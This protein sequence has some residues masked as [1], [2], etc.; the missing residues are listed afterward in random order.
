MGESQGGNKRGI[1]IIVPSGGKKKKKE[2]KVCLCGSPHVTEKEIS[3]ITA[4]TNGGKS[5]WSKRIH[6]YYKDWYFY[7]FN[8]GLA[9]NRCEFQDYLIPPNLIQSLMLQTVAERNACPFLSSGAI[10]GYRSNTAKAASTELSTTY[11]IHL[12]IK[13]KDGVTREFLQFDGQR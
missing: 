12:Q 5:Y 2:K 11:H 7:L 3:R 6:F 8:K 10:S 13:R 9:S 1:D 4:V